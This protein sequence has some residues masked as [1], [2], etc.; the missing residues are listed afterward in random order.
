MP[1]CV[2]GVLHTFRRFGIWFARRAPATSE[3][4]DHEGLGEGGVPLNSVP[5]PTLR[6]SRTGPTLSLASPTTLDQH[7]PQLVRV[8]SSVRHQT[9]GPA[10][11]PLRP[12]PYDPRST[13]PPSH[14]SVPSQGQGPT[15]ADID[16]GSVSYF[17]GARDVRIGRYNVNFLAPRRTVFDRAY[18]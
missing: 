14:I 17:S 5:I 6:T 2:D 1:L 13:S 11:N 4:Q 9:H 18:A 7:G 10:E 12:Q 15:P 8:P 16:A 3:T